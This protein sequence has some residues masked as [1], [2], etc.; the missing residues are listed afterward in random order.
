MPIG[1]A[2]SPRP[3]ADCRTRRCNGEGLARE[4]LL[5]VSSFAPGPGPDLYIRPLM[6]K[7]SEQI[8]QTII[9]EAKVGAGGAFAQ[10]CLWCSQ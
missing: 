2:Q 10:Q 4:T 9:I 1:P 7:I 3:S 8:G 6:Q 5:Y